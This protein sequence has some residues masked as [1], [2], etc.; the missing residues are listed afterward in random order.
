M[1]KENS[2]DIKI[3]PA[4]P[5]MIYEQ[6]ES[7]MTHTSFQSEY[8][9]YQCIRS[10]KVEEVDQAITQSLNAGLIIGDLSDH[11]LHQI[12]YW[13]VACISVAIHY[14]ILG[15][16]DETDAFNLSDIY[17]RH[18]DQMKTMEEAIPYLKE[19]ALELTQAVHNANQLQITSPIIRNCIH[20]IHVHLH[21]RL[22]IVDLAQELNVSRDYLSTLFRRET[23]SSLHQYILD[24]KLE[25]S[26][27]MLSNG[28][29]YDTISYDLGF[30]SE[31]HYITVFKKKY[32]MT[33]RE[34]RNQ[35]QYNL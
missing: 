26:L 13:C 33:P 4:S 8:H 35:I 14:A 15:G 25:E 10:G 21:E 24:Q 28:K 17:I 32:H 16:L 29:N 34:Y 18:I 3:I 9:L 7:G 27:T 5:N 2:F 12:H 20:Y 23:G 6:R 30:C 31:T 22:R 11:A 19:K 1:K